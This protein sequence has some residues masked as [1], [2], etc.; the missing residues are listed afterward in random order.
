MIWTIF[1]EFIFIHSGRTEYE[2][3]EEFPVNLLHELPRHT[4]LDVKDIIVVSLEYGANFS[5]AG[6]D[7]FRGDRATGEPS[8]AHR[9]NF[10]HPVFYY[11]K[12]LPTGEK[13]W[14]INKG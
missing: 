8:E 13:Q 9:S 5:G 2:Y 1:C 10:L 4:G 3:I 6:N 7:I 14:L 11:Y 12:S